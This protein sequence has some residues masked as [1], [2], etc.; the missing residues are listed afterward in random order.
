MLAVWV[1][2]ALLGGL[3]LGA[4]VA[5]AA[6]QAPK[7]PEPQKTE[8]Q[9]TESQKAEA[10]KPATAHAAV[11]QVT[12]DMMAIIKRSTQ[13]IADDPKT[14][15]QQVSDLLEPVVAFTFIAKSVM[16]KHYK[17]A[18]KN[19]REAFAKT[20][21]SSMVETFAKGLATYS[22][23]KI[24]TIPP[25]EDVSGQRRVQVVQEVASK[26]GAST[27]SYT[28]VK[29]KTG[30]WFLTNVILNGINLGS[31][32]QQQF[33]QAMRQHEND[34]NKVIATWGES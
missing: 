24:T 27:V 22:D 17:Q 14:Y 31:T 13:L 6:E 33:A 23:F 19:Q 15:Y 12:D 29:A 3:V 18:T 5:T 10:L 32:F 4:N 1:R 30:D 21:Q 25:T 34:I 28:M 2:A 11:T 9:K 20:F 16:G 7:T 8:P 26:D